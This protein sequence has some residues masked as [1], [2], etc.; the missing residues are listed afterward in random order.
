[1][2][3]DI[4]LP[5]VIGNIV[6]ELNG[7]ACG[8]ASASVDHNLFN[9]RYRCLAI[10]VAML[11]ASFMPVHFLARRL[12]AMPNFG[13]DDGEFFLISNTAI[14]LLMSRI[15]FFNITSLRSSEYGSTTCL[16]SVPVRLRIFN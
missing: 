8:C 7:D 14:G 5:S 3:F 2:K 15:I 6:T 1:M 16:D 13:A 9:G 10:F 4:T 12:S 11:D